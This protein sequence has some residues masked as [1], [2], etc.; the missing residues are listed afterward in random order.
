MKETFNSPICPDE[1]SEDLAQQ[2]EKDGY[3]AFDEVLSRQEVEQV[4]QAMSL[5]IQRARSRNRDYTINGPEVSIYQKF[6]RAEERQF[7]IQYESG[8]DKSKIS[9]ENAEDYVRKLMWYVD[10]DPIF[11]YICNRHPKVKMCLEGVL[12]KN[13]LSFQEMALIKPP[14]IGDERAWHQDDSY[15]AVKPLEAVAG[16]WIAV[17]QATVENGCMHVIPGD[18][19]RGPILQTK[20]VGCQIPKERLE[21]NRA[22]PV[23]LRPGGMMIFSGLLP[24][25]TPKNTSPH[26]RRALQF[27][28]RT[29]QSEIVTKTEYETLF[30]ED[31]QSASCNSW[32]YKQN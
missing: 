5:L 1:W 28:Y 27:H 15:F 19:K 6:D 14:L 21:L 22:V 26:R 9:D 13:P 12:G 24:H 3:L 20:A 10:E 17:D 2:Y 8:V 25:Y 18:H 4:K 32:M 7:Y 29:A 11:Q 16:I 23:T 31:G 30:V